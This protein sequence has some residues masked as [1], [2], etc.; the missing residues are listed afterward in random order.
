[1]LLF[2]DFDD[3]RFRDISG[4]PDAGRIVQILPAFPS[5]APLDPIEVFAVAACPIGL[6]G[7]ATSD[8]KT[9]KH[10]KNPP[11][12]PPQKTHPPPRLGMAQQVLVG[13]QGPK[14][15]V[16]LSGIRPILPRPEPARL[17]PSVAFLDQTVSSNDSL[18]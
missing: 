6:D 11:P 12:K 18:N 10:Q 4:L 13:I 7:E 16:F 2:T 5:W 14:E 9:P 8:P 15:L 17:A 3:D 1:V